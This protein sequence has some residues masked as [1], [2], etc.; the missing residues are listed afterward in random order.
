MWVPDQ[1]QLALPNRDAIAKHQEDYFSQ[2]IFVQQ[3]DTGEEY[4]G[5]LVGDAR[6]WSLLCET[7]E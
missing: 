2:I 3:Q 7:S 4:C 1:P 6:S 5:Y